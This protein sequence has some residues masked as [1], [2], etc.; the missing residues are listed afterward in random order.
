[1]TN[2]IF[3]LAV[4]LLLAGMGLKAQTAFTEQGN[5]LIGSTVGFS[6]NESRLKSS[7]Q[8]GSAEGEGPYS[9]QW[10]LNPH[11]GYFL[12]DNFNLGI[13]LDYT[14]SREKQPNADKTDDSDL[15][16]GPFARLYLPLGDDQAFF[17]EGNFGFGN[18]SDNLIIGGAP[19]SINSNII[20]VGA[21][22]G[23]TIFS[24]RAVGLEALFKYNYARTKFQTTENGV[25]TETTS[26]TNQF[27]VSLGVQ[28]YFGGFSKAY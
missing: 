27:A 2:R 24:S 11:I 20:A 14:F 22:P 4:S 16:F 12:L 1:M 28:F 7:T 26:R 15:L 8:S 21:G 23:F 6:S 25:T 9:L 19:Q 10:N 18:S 13:G 5:F 3:F 17:L